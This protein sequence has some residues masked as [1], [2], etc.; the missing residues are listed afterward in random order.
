[1]KP[2]ASNRGRVA[3]LNPYGVQDRDANDSANQDGQNVALG[4]ASAEVSDDERLMDRDSRGRSSCPYDL[5]SDMDDDFADL[6]ILSEEDVR[7]AQRAAMR[8]L[9]VLADVANL[10]SDDEDN[11]TPE[12]FLALA[13]GS[14]RRR[15]QGRRLQL[16]RAKISAWFAAFK[17]GVAGLPELV[18]LLRLLLPLGKAR[19]K[20]ISRPLIALFWRRRTNEDDDDAITR[21]LAMWTVRLDDAEQHWNDFKDGLERVTTWLDTRFGTRAR[22]GALVVSD[23]RTTRASRY[24]SRQATVYAADNVKTSQTSTPVFEPTVIPMVERTITDND[25]EV[26]TNVEYV[27]TPT[28]FFWRIEDQDDDDKML[29][30]LRCSLPSWYDTIQG[31][32]LGDA[33]R[34]V[35]DILWMGVYYDWLVKAIPADATTAARAHRDAWLAVTNGLGNGVF[36]RACRLIGLEL[37]L[38]LGRGP[39]PIVQGWHLEQECLCTLVGHRMCTNVGLLQ[40]ELRAYVGSQVRSNNGVVAGE[41]SSASRTWAS[42]VANRWTIKRLRPGGNG[43]LQPVS[44]H[45]V[46]LASSGYLSIPTRAEMDV[47]REVSRETVVQAAAAAVAHGALE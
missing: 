28:P 5:P 26:V 33:G 38:D 35:D 18:R 25:V 10:S 36:D 47:I 29:P 6:P 37:F 23:L 1:M 40:R 2:M 4:A 17:T 27:I 42:Q 45:L 14:E 20:T 43:H 24:R 44:D 3:H 11:I 46:L 34:R 21:Q 39:R 32:L 12:E 19:L 22:Q 8:D 9:G 31:H 15:K 13:E 16:A 41:T 30:S 7:A